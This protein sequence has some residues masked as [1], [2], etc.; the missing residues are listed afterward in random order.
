MDTWNSL[1]NLS[2]SLIIKRFLNYLSIVEAVAATVAI[3]ILYLRILSFTFQI[4]LSVSMQLQSTNDSYLGLQQ[5][6][7]HSEI[8]TFLSSSWSAS[9]SSQYSYTVNPIN[10]TEKHTSN[11]GFVYDRVTQQLIG[12]PEHSHFQAH[13]S[14]FPHPTS[15]F[16]RGIIICQGFN[17]HHDS[18]LL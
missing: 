9:N 3:G 4:N 17:S 10:D 2:A 1:R 14:L 8:V 5:Q 15:F 16:P 12:S 7:Q 13:D 18:I 11:F 6:T